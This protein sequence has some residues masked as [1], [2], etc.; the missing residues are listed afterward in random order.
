MVTAN[1]HMTFCY[2]SGLGTDSTERG[3]VMWARVKGKTDNALLALPFKGPSCLLRRLVPDSV[4]TTV[5][6]GR[7]LIQVAAAGHA[8]PILY[9]RDINLLGA[10]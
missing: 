1:P 6:V 3:R 8:R 2:I 7:A 9:S 10:T 4:T 5:N